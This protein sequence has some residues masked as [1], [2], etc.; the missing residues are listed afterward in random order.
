MNQRLPEAGPIVPDSQTTRSPQIFSPQRSWREATHWYKGY[1]TA[2]YTNQTSRQ[3]PTSSFSMWNHIA[4]VAMTSPGIL[5]ELEDQ[6]KAALREHIC[7]N[8]RLICYKHAN[9]IRPISDIESLYNH[10]WVYQKRKL[11]PCRL[12]RPASQ[13]PLPPE[14]DTAT[15]FSEF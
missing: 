14:V 2:P 4:R 8:A 1:P 12:Q 9:R 3:S 10:H 11:G 7:Q 5:E 6:D 15:E 13:P